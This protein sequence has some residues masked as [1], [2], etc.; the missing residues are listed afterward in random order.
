MSIRRT[1]LRD[2]SSVAE[3]NK[4]RYYV[5]I[6][7]TLYSHWVYVSIDKNSNLATNIDFN[8]NHIFVNDMDKDKR[9]YCQLALHALEL[10][11]M[12]KS[13]M[14]YGDRTFSLNCARKLG[15]MHETDIPKPD[16]VMIKDYV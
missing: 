2:N 14:F 6:Y 11:T 13:K 10:Y 9:S 3:K 7:F 12:L 8:T 15:L 16:L 1:L 4:T 5:A